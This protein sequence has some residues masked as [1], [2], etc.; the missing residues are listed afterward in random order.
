MSFIQSINPRKI[1]KTIDPDD[2]VLVFRERILQY[3]LLVCLVIGLF[4]L[5]PNLPGPIQRGQWVFVTIYISIYLGVVI[6]ALSRNLPYQLRAGL[7]MAVM[8]IL[9]V[10]SMMESG[11]SGDSRVFL[12][13]FTILTATLLGL[14]KGVFAGFLAIATM[15][16]TGW[17]MSSGKIPLPPIEVLANSNNFLEWITAGLATL[18]M[19]A[20]T[21][22]AIITLINGLQRTAQKEKNLSIELSREKDSLEQR[23]EL[24]TKELQKRASQLEAASEIA[25]DV[26]K[27]SNLDELLPH[28]VDSI[29]DRFGYYHAGVFLLDERNEYAVLRAATGEA[30]RAML[31]GG[32]RLRIGEV[33][34]VGYV[35]SKGEPRIALDVGSDPFHFKNPLLPLTRSEMT[36][37]LKVGDQ[38]IGALDVQS[39][40]Q[41][42]F[43]VEDIRVMQIIADQLAVAIEKARVVDQL[44]QNVNELEMSYQQYTRKAWRAHLKGSRKNYAYRYR[45]EKIEIDPTENIDLNDDLQQSDPIVKTFEAGSQYEKPVTTVAIPIRLRNQIIGIVDVQFDN[46]KIPGE[47]VSMLETITNRLALALENARLL[48]DNQNRAER[49][50]LIGNISAKVR[51]S[52]NMDNV[53]RIAAAEL[54][55]SLGISEVLVQLKTTE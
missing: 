13:I 21:I 30:G 23:I 9:G 31:A 3:I 32:H 19:G 8:Y 55:Q 40:K 42:A 33:G 45:M 11:L 24:R 35:V 7:T 15:V 1:P 10:S 27:I 48:E 29:R 46:Q 5:I 26:S 49:E 41:E 37:P 53:L 34:L 47:M 44:K 39:E 2:D 16:I 51:A 54:G 22:A 14:S 17:F 18:L 28:S 4:E 50:K 52:T 6:L 20:I 43:S 38:I 25:Q 12:L 36:L